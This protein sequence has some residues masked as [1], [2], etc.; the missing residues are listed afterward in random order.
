[1][2]NT[3]K[4]VIKVTVEIN[5][6]IE[7]VWELWATPAD[8]M[9]WNNISD[10]WHT[11]KVENDVRIGGE[12]LFVMG[13]KNG[14]FNF[15]FTGVYTEV[16]VNESMAYTLDDGRKSTITFTAGNPVKITESFEPNDNDPIDMQ[17]DFCK[18]VLNKFKAY[19]E[20]KNDTN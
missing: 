7:K 20:S 19:A 2:D 12:F 5:A 14:S 16:K 6:P 3:A 9:Q 18:A 8:I 17:R 15:N 1:M 11:P 13:L 10:E 4:T